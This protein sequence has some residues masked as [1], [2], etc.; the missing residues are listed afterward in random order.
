MY[1]LYNTHAYVPTYKR[2]KCINVY[3]VKLSSL[4]ELQKFEIDIFEKFSK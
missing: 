1:A 2:K 4:Q 3:H